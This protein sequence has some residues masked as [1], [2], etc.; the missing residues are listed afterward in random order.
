VVDKV[1]TQTTH[2]TEKMVALV[3]VALG[4]GE[5]LLAAQEPLGKEMLALETIVLI[6]TQVAAAAVLVQWVRMALEV[7]VVMGVLV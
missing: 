3:A 6:H 4:T 1:G 5:E 7:L 2:K